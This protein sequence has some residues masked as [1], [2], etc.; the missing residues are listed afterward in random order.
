MLKIKKDGSR[1]DRLFFV[2]KWGSTVYNGFML[3]KISL[4]LP[5]YNE[6]AILQPVL[7]RYL[8]DLEKCGKKYEVVAINDGC[9]D[10]S[11]DVLK[12]F[13]QKNRAFRVITLAG[14]SGKQASINAGME[15]CDKQSDAIILADID[16]LN[17]LGCIR[18]VIDELDKGKQIVYAKREDLGFDRV[19]TAVSHLAVVAGTKLFGI[20]GIYTG[21]TD[22][23]AYAR[24][25]ADVIIAIPTRNK[26]MR[27]MDTW[28]G[29]E[30]DYIEYASG[31]SKIEEKNIIADLHK[32][33]KETPR[34]KGHKSLKRDR[35]REHT[36]A[37]DF[38]IAMGLVALITLIAGILL[39][40]RVYTADF[41]VGVA[42]WVAT[43]AFALTAIVFLFQAVLIKRVG[44]VFK[45]HAVEYQIRETIN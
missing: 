18:K 19:S 34:I 8:D 33:A 42:L 31:Y 40:A 37:T 45:K 28:L 21:V 27:T 39:G 1:E 5:I 38:S 32:K 15:L 14:R 2:A 10:G 17:P 4:V 35:V 9:T 11:D 25:V 13:A 16:I 12:R 29:W 6:V 23:M 41:W 30:I 26:Y 7:E 36:P 20:D 22:I 3:S 24:P 43:L 44:L